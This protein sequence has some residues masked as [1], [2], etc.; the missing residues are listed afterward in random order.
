[1]LAWLA[2]Q[3][4]K[5][6]SF[7]FFSFYFQNIIFTHK[8]II[9]MYNFSFYKMFHKACVCVCI[10]VQS[11]STL[12]R[13]KD[14]NL[15]GSSIHGISQARILELVVISFSRRLCSVA[16]GKKTLKK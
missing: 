16:T 11:C 15:P 14:G 12:L 4:G 7:F 13:P 9:K 10:C 6:S 1:M 5:L 3:H 2:K 8:N